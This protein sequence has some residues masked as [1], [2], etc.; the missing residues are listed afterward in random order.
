MFHADYSGEVSLRV[1]ARARIRAALAGRRIGVGEIEYVKDEIVRVRAVRLD[2]LRCSSA[3]SLG[4]DATI[5]LA[6]RCLAA[7]TIPGSGLVFS[8]QTTRKAPIGTR[9]GGEGGGAEA[10]TPKKPTTSF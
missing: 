2:C 1:I 6:L 7:V 3:K 4:S 10:Q 5:R 8:G 9:F